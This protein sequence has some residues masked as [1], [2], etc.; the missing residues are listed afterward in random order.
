[1]SAKDNRYLLLTRSCQCNVLTGKRGNCDQMSLSACARSTRLK[2]GG[3]LS[4]MF[5]SQLMPSGPAFHNSSQQHGQPEQSSKPDLKV[6]KF[7]SSA[8]YTQAS[9][10]EAVTCIMICFTA[11][12]I[13]LA[14]P[15]LKSAAHS[16]C[17]VWRAVT[18]TT[19]SFSLAVDI[20]ILEVGRQAKAAGVIILTG[21][22]TLPSESQLCI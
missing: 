21:S 17:P 13:W 22:I 6:N 10:K 11:F 2:L 7:C 20:V 3:L 4:S 12:A 8:V 9:R 16:R 14:S 5:A 18:I 1:M 15:S 19:T